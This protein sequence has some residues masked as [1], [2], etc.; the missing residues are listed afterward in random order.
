MKQLTLLLQHSTKA[1]AAM[2]LL[3]GL[4]FV[5]LVGIALAAPV[6]G[7]QQVPMY[8]S[9]CDIYLYEGDI[10][11]LS[12]P[13]GSI[14]LD[15][16]G[17]FYVELD[18][19]SGSSDSETYTICSADDVTGTATVSTTLNSGGWIADAS[20]SYYAYNAQCHS[21]WWDPPCIDTTGPISFAAIWKALIVL[22]SNGGFA[23]ARV[24]F[25]GCESEPTPT[26]TA[27]P[28]ITP[29]ATLTPTA[30]PTQTAT[31]PPITPL[32]S[33]TLFIAY[34]SPTPSRT[35]YPVPTLWVAPE[36][37]SVCGDPSSI[38]APIIESL[39]D[40]IYGIEE[41]DS[42]ISITST[43]PMTVTMDSNPIALAKGLVALMGDITWLAILGAWFFVAILVILTLV[44]VR[45]IVGF[46]G[47]IKRIIDIIEL[48]PGM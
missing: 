5:G 29:T 31:P 27:T 41:I 23:A 33:P 25:D 26:P 45:F 10:D 46:W 9:S 35:P 34:P 22:Q 43:L 8:Q 24:N 36:P 15:E 2:A 1:R 16:T 13:T 40:T 17:E 47:V 19:P 6:A 37:A 20:F 3:A 7:P 48:I 21:S 4:G 44:A 18:L 30:T 14:H 42:K 28:T 11:C 32:P 39:D 38:F 12:P